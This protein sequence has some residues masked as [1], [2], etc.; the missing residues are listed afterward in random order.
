MKIALINVLGKDKSTGKMISSFAKA[1]R[2]EGHDTLIC[3]GRKPI[4][5][6]DGYF[7]YSSDIEVVF[8][9]LQTRVTNKEGYYS[10]HATKKLIR[11][12]KQYR[13]DRVIMMNLHDHH[14]NINM[15]FDYLSGEG[16]E[17]VHILC[18]EFP[19]TG[20]CTYAGDCDGYMSD[21][22]ECKL[23][24]EKAK[25]MFRDRIVRYDAF[26][27]RIAFATSGHLLGR[28]RAS[29][30]LKDRLVMEI[31][32]GIDIDFFHPV[33]PSTLKE[34]LGI[35]EDAICIVNIA[36]FSNERKGVRYFL[37]AARKMKN[38]K[39][40]VFINVGYDGDENNIPDNF[41]GINYVSNQAELREYYSLADAFVCTSTM[42]GM[43]NVCIEALCCGTPL[44]CF[45][46]TGTEQI[47]PEP[48]LKKCPVGTDDL[49]TAIKSINKKEKPLADECVR[50]ATDRY[51]YRRGAR[52]LLHRPCGLMNDQ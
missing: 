38:D 25:R 43:P 52:I 30:A 50:Y 41:K 6:E 34:R 49:I 11:K 26:G 37:E 3:Y 17:T 27:D 8:D 22:S 1:F 7:R 21:C 28:A 23:F 4:I 5:K 32:P 40:Y 10:K 29:T 36:P 2:E 24:G 9:Y 20:G 15:L 16:V 46:C 13:P 35:K 51:D 33:D 19:Y 12:L 31:D 42:D 18:D 39:E 45:D 44:L 14:L 48:M 47:A